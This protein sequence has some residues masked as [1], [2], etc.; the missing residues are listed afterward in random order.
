MKL[1]QVVSENVSGLA[2]C[3]F[4][5][6][7]SILL[8][9]RFKKPNAPPPCG[10]CATRA[11]FFFHSWCVH[12]CPMPRLLLILLIGG[13]AMLAMTASRRRERVADF[14]IWRWDIYNPETKKHK[15]IQGFGSLAVWQG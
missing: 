4:F 5:F 3:L 11:Q 13:V 12:G 1:E 6:L 2:A 14:R 10:Q 15:E 8:S 7:I 9:T